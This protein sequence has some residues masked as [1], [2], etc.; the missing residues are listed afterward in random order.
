MMRWLRKFLY[1]DDE[2]VRVAAG[3][4]EPE[5]RM[6]QELLANNGVHAMV[7]SMNQLSLHQI[8]SLGSDFDV[9][10]KQSDVERANDILTPRS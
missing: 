4:S 2:I 1:S 7:K 3:L 8:G 9:L 10:V 6:W 5:A